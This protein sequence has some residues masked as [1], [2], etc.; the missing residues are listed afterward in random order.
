MKETVAVTGAEAIAAMNTEKT[1]FRSNQR[2]DAVRRNDV[3]CAS[4]YFFISFSY[5]NYN[6]ITGYGLATP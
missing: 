6:F 1:G 3:G 5:F 2:G 4:P